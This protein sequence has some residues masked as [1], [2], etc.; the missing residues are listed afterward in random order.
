MSKPGKNRISLDACRGGHYDAGA[1]YADNAIGKRI[2]EGRRRRGLSQGEFASLLASFGIRI[3]LRGYAKWETGET[4]PN[5]YQLLA[6]YHALQPPEGESWLSGGDA[7]LNEEGLRKLDEYREDLM[8][9][10]RYKPAARVADNAV[11]Y[12]EALLSRLRPS[13]G[14]GNFLD[15][16]N[17]EK[18]LFPA[19]SI[20]PGADFAICVDGNSMEPVYRDGQ[21][22]WIQLCRSLRVGEVGL[23][24]Y[25]GNSYI[26]VYG[27]QPPAAELLPWFTDSE[28]KVF[29]Q[30]V[31]IS[32]NREQ[33]P[34]VPVHPEK[35]FAVIGRVL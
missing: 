18:R 3:G 32:Y 30:P 4:V 25:D 16:E 14:P 11:E 2:A 23:M 35:G 17:F 34:P 33:Y 19:D 13:A 7:L 28:G 27:E 20:P 10:G 15:E 29:P 22:L 31:L 1:A 5:A 6:I 12:R 21:L 24:C 26:K 9:S 8:A